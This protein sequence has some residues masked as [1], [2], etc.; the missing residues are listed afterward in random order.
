MLSTWL[1]GFIGSWFIGIVVFGLAGA[2]HAQSPAAGWIRGQVVS[3]VPVALGDLFVEMRP[4]SGGEAIRTSVS[5]DGRFEVETVAVSAL[6]GIEI[7]VL[8]RRGTVLHRET[9]TI[10]AAPL[11]IALAA[12]KV[13][14][15]VGAVVSV[16]DLRRPLSKEFRKAMRRSE[17]AFGRNDLAEAAEH[18]S[19]AVEIEPQR[20]EAYAR[21]GV[22]LLQMNEYEQALRAFDQAATIAPEEE[23]VQAG[24]AMALHGLGRL[25]EAESQVRLALTAHPDSARCH[26]VLGLILAQTGRR[27][28][29]TVTHLKR[30]TTEYPHA[31]LVLAHVYAGREQSQKAQDALRQ[32]V[33]SV[34]PGTQHH[35]ACVEQLRRLDAYRSSK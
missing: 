10:T 31:L 20:V 7:V 17:R 27:D 5:S 12:P 21:L 25:P 18:L 19:S 11:K 28:D 35:T 23:P 30:A 26:Y 22:V 3:E 9:M 8:N 32:C 13:A 1:H 14:E 15:P 6:D 24:R 34:D 2:A 33:Q 29:K 16:D 4:M